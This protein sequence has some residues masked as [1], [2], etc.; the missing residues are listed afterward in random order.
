MEFSPSLV[1][2]PW[3]TS[4]FLR[5][6]SSNMHIHKHE[7]YPLCFFFQPA[8]EKNDLEV[9]PGLRQV[10]PLFF[11]VFFNFHL[12]NS[13]SNLKTVVFMLLSSVNVELALQAMK[14]LKGILPQE[15]NASHQ[16]NPEKNKERGRMVGC[17]GK[18]IITQ[19]Y[20]HVA[21]S[22]LLLSMVQL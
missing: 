18:I 13:S 17:S 4:W 19:L 9:G 2:R 8:N 7:S 14:C 21:N 10:Q 11:V 6:C 16:K 3:I 22:C 5:I 15:T 12:E 20:M 1:H